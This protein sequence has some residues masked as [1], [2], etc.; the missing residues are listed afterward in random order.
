ME[1]E[2]EMGW[3]V[4]GFLLAAAP[5]PLD[6]GTIDLPA[7]VRCQW[8]RGGT[9]LD[10]GCTQSLQTSAAV[11]GSTGPEAAK[12]N[13]GGEVSVRVSRAP[14]AAMRPR[15]RSKAVRVEAQYR[16]EVVS[17]RWGLPVRIQAQ[18][19]LLLDRGP[20]AGEAELAAGGPWDRARDAARL[21]LFD[22]LEPGF[23]T[24]E[25]KARVFLGTAS[26]ETPGSRADGPG[27]D[28]RSRHLT[29]G[30]RLAF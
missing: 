10:R 3:A 25:G 5:G 23:Q 24:G 7:D 16:L 13:A 8:G 1:E 26:D 30:L 22:W 27:P 21:L 9:A 19:G 28:P 17:N 15:A 18:L 20:A 4:L 29:V 11:L 2:Q 14:A 6:G 12:V